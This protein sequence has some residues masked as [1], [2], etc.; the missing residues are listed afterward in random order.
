MA[1][2][3]V[4]KNANLEKL[5][6]KGEME[7][8]VRKIIRS[9]LTKARALMRGYAKESMD[10]DPRKAYLAVRTSVYRR[11][12]GGNMHIYGSR[13]RGVMA[14]YH[15]RRKLDLN[16][17]QRGGNRM[18][19]SERTKQID[20]YTGADRGFILRW[21]DKGTDVRSTKTGANRGRMG[22]VGF[23]RSHSTQVMQDAAQAISNL[24][25]QEVSR[26]FGKQ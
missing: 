22:G 26:E 17:R 3:V 11:I 5:L 8:R 13:R 6:L 18:P 16:P 23:F 20:S 24:I 12:L 25:A 15:P 14:D 21:I 7:E 2:I 19:R 9:V 1:T 10:Y 4:E